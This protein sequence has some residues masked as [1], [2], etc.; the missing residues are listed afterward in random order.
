MPQAISTKRESPIKA[1]STSLMPDKRLA[2]RRICSISEVKN[3]SNIQV[4]P[5]S[6]GRERRK[7]AKTL[8]LK[9]L[10]I[11]FLLELGLQKARPLF[12]PVDGL[13]VFQANLRIRNTVGYD[14]YV[15]EK[16]A[17]APKEAGVKG[18]VL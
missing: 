18:G 9:T 17:D 13:N 14:I 8:R 1:N 15:Q 3:T 11:L 16:L 4:A 12:P 10:S 7:R 2:S 5:K 6:Q